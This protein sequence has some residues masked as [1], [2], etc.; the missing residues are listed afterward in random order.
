MSGLSSVCRRRGHDDPCVDG[1]SAMYG[2]RIV[3][4]ALQESTRPNRHPG[5]GKPAPENG[6]YL[7]QCGVRRTWAVEFAARGEFT[8]PTSRD[9]LAKSPSAPSVPS[10]VGPFKATSWL[11][12]RR[13]SHA[14]FYAHSPL[15]PPTRRLWARTAAKTWFTR[16]PCHCSE[17]LGRAAFNLNHFFCRHNSCRLSN[18]STG[19]P[20]HRSYIRSGNERTPKCY[21]SS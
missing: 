1:G 15:R 7:L 17:W 9:P 12:A 14:A 4:R 13:H 21:R 3:C 2:I 8:A 20:R 10:G 6:T 18:T 19:G 11:L 16:N 5:Y